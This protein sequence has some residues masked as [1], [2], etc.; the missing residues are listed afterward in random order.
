MLIGRLLNKNESG[1]KWA[2]HE[3]IITES[4]RRRVA[5]GRSLEDKGFS[6]LADP[7]GENFINEPFY[8]ITPSNIVLTSYEIYAFEKIGCAG[9]LS[10]E[11][12]EMK[13]A[14]E[15]LVSYSPNFF[16]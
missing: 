1:S 14:Y 3:Q 13:D 8:V 5:N 6:L 7:T 11:R 4:D 10:R 16:D 15:Y 9:L 12:Q 2:D